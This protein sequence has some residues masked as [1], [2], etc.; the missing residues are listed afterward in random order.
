MTITAGAVAIV[1]GGS[2]GIGAAAA[3]AL[4]DAGARVA[5]LA[6][7]KP[8]LDGVVERI[9]NAGGEAVGVPVDITDADAVLGAREAVREHFGPAAI[10]VNN[11]A[12]GEPLGRVWEVDPDQVR[13]C[14]EVNFNGAMHVLRAFVP[15]MI[16]AGTGR[17]VAVSSNAGAT[18]IPTLGIYG[19]TKAAFERLH[20]VAAAE[21][22]GTGVLVN[23]LW[24]GGV[25]TELQG[26]LRDD[27]FAY[28]EMARDVHSTGRL[29]TPEQVAPTIVTLCSQECA[30]TGEIVN[31]AA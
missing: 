31:I 9:V 14:S 26:M 15:D 27:R 5:V 18:S 24:P 7:S 28:A 6:R 29:R 20:L 16:E 8:D 2:R 13:R 22:A 4:A 19:A 12:I 10:L 23:V 1:S 25:D 3:I 17:I 30:D 21:L 11:A